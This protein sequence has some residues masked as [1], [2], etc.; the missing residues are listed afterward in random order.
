MKSSIMEEKN[1]DTEIVS[2]SEKSAYVKDEQTEKK[3]NPLDEENCRIS[4]IEKI[5]ETDGY[6]INTTEGL[7]MYPMLRN[8]RDTIVIYPQKERL[9]KYDVALYRIDNRYIL[10]R[11]IKVLPD[12]YVIRGDNRMDKEYGITDDMILGVLT[13]FY[14]DEKKIDLNGWKYKLYARIWNFIFPLRLFYKKTRTLLGRLKRKILK[15]GM[16]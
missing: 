4:K 6:F 5:I 11:V 15:T 14:R 16:D 3:E 8:R 1:K 13:E 12:S 2:K 9:K 10:H 7:S